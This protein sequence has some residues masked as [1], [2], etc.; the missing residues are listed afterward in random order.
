MSGLE[1]KRILV[2]GA[3]GGIGSAAARC[4]T[5]AGASVVG[6]DLVGEDDIIRAD[7]TQQEDAQAAVADGLARLGGIDILVNNAG[8]GSASDAG[9]F[10]GE[11]ARLVMEVNLFGAWTMTAACMPHL[12]ESQG[13]VI[14]VSS[15]LSLVDVPF[16]AAY[17]AS[18][19]ALDAYSAALRLEYRDRIAVTTL[20]P[21]YIRTSIHD[22]AAASGATLEGMVRAD[23]VDQAADALLKACVRRPRML[24]TSALTAVE[25]WAAR[26]FRRSSER[27]LAR[28]FERW[29]RSRPLPS[30]LRY[31]LP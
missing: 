4:L 25:L 27:V 28:R 22:G 21:G 23:T 29:K 6:I 3:A 11:M 30:F 19:R 9:D 2:T 12:L 24:T 14:N 31:P 20:H 26:R 17:S 18:K 1:G 16:A 10:P 13:H 7:V 15:G 5:G 8:I